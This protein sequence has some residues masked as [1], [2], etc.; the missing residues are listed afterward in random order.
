MLDLGWSELLVIAAVALIVVGPK[1]L[2][3]M[4]RTI[5]KFMRVIR[6]QA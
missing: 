2:P 6:Q 1:E 4:L 5:G 3:G